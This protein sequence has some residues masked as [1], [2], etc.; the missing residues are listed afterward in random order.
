VSLSH[1]QLGSKI[2]GSFSSAG[3]LLVS[4]FMLFGSSC[5]QYM[6]DRVESHHVESHHI[7][8]L[9]PLTESKTKTITSRSRNTIVACC[10]WF[11]VRGSLLVGSQSGQA[12]D[13]TNLTIKSSVS[14]S[15]RCKADVAAI[16]DAV[17]WDA[18]ML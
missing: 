11:V 12:E 8:R 15:G 13:A 2:H 18:V 4:W 3:V 5:S 6:F 7:E 10:S 9:F 16:W 1:S 14:V 17:I